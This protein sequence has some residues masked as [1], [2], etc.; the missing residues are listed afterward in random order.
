[1]TVVDQLLSPNFVLH[2]SHNPAM[3]I[4]GPAG[5]KYFVT[6]FRWA[7]PDPKTDAGGVVA[8]GDKVV[9]R[10]SAPGTH[11]GALMRIPATG[12]RVTFRG[13]DVIRF[14]TARSRSSGR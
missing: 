7:F 10:W 12:T 3:D 8:E 2:A 11:K 13:V 14:V 1:M 4:R 9:A 5:C 6:V